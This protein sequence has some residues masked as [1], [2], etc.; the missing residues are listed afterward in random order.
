MIRCSRVPETILLALL[1]LVVGSASAAT[2]RVP[3]DH[4]TIQAAVDAAQGGDVVLVSPGTYRERVRLKND[5]LLKSAGDDG[6]GQLGLK[7]A[8]ATIIDGGGREGEGPGVVMAEGA[9]LDGFTVFNVGE[10]DDDE[11]KKHHATQGNEQPHDH[12]AVPGAAGIV[13]GVTCTIKNNIV[14]HNGYTGIA[15][16]GVQGRSCSPH[17]FSNVCYRNMGGG[18]GS[19][20]GSTAIIERNVCF[21][22]FYAGIGH[23]GA[24]PLVIHNVC[25]ENVRAGIG[26][27]EGA[28]PVVRGN[29]CYRNRRAGVGIRTGPD[30]RPVVE[31]NNCYQ[32]DMAGIGCDEQSAPIVRGNRCYENS[33][34]GIGCRD[35]STPL[36]VGNKC[37]RNKAAGI[38]SEL[39]ARPI[40][41]DNECFENEDAGIGQR[42]GAE[43][44][45]IGNHLHHNK[46]AG[47]GFAECETGSSN[48]IDNRVIDNEKVAVGI[49]TGWKVLL[50][51]NEL[52]RQDGL[53][54][55]VMVFQGAEADFSNNVLRG[56]GVAGIRTEGIT[57]VANNTF[58][59]PALREAGPP[60]FAVWGLPGSDIVM[61]R[62]T[63]RG[64]RHALVAEK[65]A[66]TFCDNRITAYGRVGVKIDE[67]SG[68]PIVVRNRFESDRD[69]S[70]VVISGGKG[71][72]ENNRV[73]S[74]AAAGDSSQ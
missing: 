54:P 12:I 61:T 1:P 2:L 17:V 70:G 26:V 8:E 50:S 13:V 68:T 49:H 29:K 7:R 45:L 31:D 15:I 65:S 73:E 36:I 52:S 63:V 38:G 47:I 69:R 24:S 57:R 64:W 11:W 74:P 66:V 43:T 33:L 56:T 14:H 4:K 37:Y 44:T 20:H 55:L 27:S 72:V 16:Q 62:S 41:A 58:E 6:R 71:L 35:R 3:Q 59:C 5:V 42:S 40:I 34:A 19:L 30:T 53:P 22:N 23:D 39:G 60:Q 67:P 46:A 21:Q 10:Y 48:V 25:Y 9:S 51:G 28:K 32:N 18:I